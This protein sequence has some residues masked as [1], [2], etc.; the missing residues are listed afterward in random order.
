MSSGFQGVGFSIPSNDV[1]E[2]LYAILERGRPI[3]GYLGVR[4]L[5]LTPRIQTL[6]KY[7][8]VGAVVVRVGEGSPAEQ[9][10]L[11]SKDVVTSFAG[12][13]INNM[14]EMFTLVQRARVGDTVDIGVW[15]DGETLTLQATVA[16]AVP[17]LAS[18]EDGLAPERVRDPKEI[19]A[20]VGIFATNPSQPGKGI[21]VRAISPGTL[22]EG[23]LEVGDRILF[24]NRTPVASVEAFHLQLAASAVAQ[25]TSIELLRDGK[26]MRILIPAVPD[27]MVDGGATSNRPR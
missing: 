4:M 3:R 13:D 25:T 17:E 5:D 27:E 2:V 16:E 7:N 24:V 1:K 19:L 21:A 6:M 15:R 11:K 18:S 9:A 10:G 14:S 23:R 26:P 12:K 22:A 8:G 20:A